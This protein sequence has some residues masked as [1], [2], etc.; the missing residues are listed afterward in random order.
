MTSHL[1]DVVSEGGHSRMA[2]KSQN[3]HLARTLPSKAVS[4]QKLF[5]EIFCLPGPI[6]YAE[7]EN[8]HW[9]ARKRRKTALTREGNQLVGGVLPTVKSRFQLPERSSWFPFQVKHSH[10]AGGDL[11]ALEEP[12]R[13]FQKLGLRYSQ[14]GGPRPLPISLQ[15]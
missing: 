13:W 5:F 2:L 3:P 7:S 1:R 10:L 8:A 9:R 14:W 4:R 12:G 11:R 15:R 6:R